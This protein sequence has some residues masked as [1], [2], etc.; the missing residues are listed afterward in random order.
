MPF[1]VDAPR[2][3][4]ALPSA[5]NIASRYRITDGGCIVIHKV[6]HSFDDGDI[7]IQ[8]NLTLRSPH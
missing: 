3:D 1:I 5:C 2:F 8:W 7:Q 4:E 6:T